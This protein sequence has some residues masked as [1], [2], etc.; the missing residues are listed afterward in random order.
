MLRWAR[1]MTMAPSTD[2]T[3][4]DAR[5]GARQPGSAPCAASASVSS[6]CQSSNT[7]AATRAGGIS[8]AGGSSTDTA[9]TGQPARNSLST[10]PPRHRPEG[11]GSGDRTGSGRVDPARVVS[12]V[13]DREQ[14]PEAVPEKRLK[15]VFVR[16]DG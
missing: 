3:T 13:F 2:A 5:T 7:P 14:L 12:H 9:G 10:T 6:R 16:A 15:P 11:R 1:H 4:T 8:S